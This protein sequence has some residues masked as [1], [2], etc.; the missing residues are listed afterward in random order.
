MQI[1]A[2]CRTRSVSTYGEIC[3][4][5]LGGG[6]G[7]LGSLIRCGGTL[8]VCV[9]WRSRIARILHSVRGDFVRLFWLAVSDRS[10][11]SLGTG[12]LCPF[13]LVGVFG[14]IGSLI[15]YGSRVRRGTST[16]VC[17]CL[18]VCTSGERCREP[19][20]SQRGGPGHDAG[21]DQHVVQGSRFECRRCERFAGIRGR[22]RKRGASHDE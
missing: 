12:I 6:L 4:F 22:R 19:R 13:V 7:S 1:K 18:S 11:P 8:Y 10:V 14:S 2:S 15:R 9:G 21:C 20:Q 17:M 3:T 16:L 5:V